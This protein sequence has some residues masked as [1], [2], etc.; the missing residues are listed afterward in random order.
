MRCVRTHQSSQTNLI[1]SYQPY[2]RGGSAAISHAAY[3]KRTLNIH[4]SLRPPWLWYGRSPCWKCPSCAS[5]F[6]LRGCKHDCPR[7]LFQPR[8]PE[9]LRGTTPVVA[10]RPRERKVR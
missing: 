6:E 1:A 7:H 5:V 10:S 8:I 4:P 3:H 2:F 9:A